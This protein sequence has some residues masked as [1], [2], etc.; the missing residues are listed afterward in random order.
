M[1]LHRI[2]SILTTLLLCSLLSGCSGVG[3]LGSTLHDLMELRSEV[4]KKFNEK[5]VNI[6]I[7]ETERH[8]AIF[9]TFIN[10]DLNNKTDAERTIRAQETAELVKARY[11]KIQSIDEIAV[12]FQRVT[13]VFLIFHY[14]E[15]LDMYGF[16]NQARL[17]PQ[18]DR[19]RARDEESKSGV[20]VT[21]SAIKKRTDIQTAA[22]Q[23]DGVPGRGLTVIPHLEIP[24]DTSEVTPKPPDKVSFDFASYSPKQRF[25]NLT[26]IA[27]ISDNKLVYQT[28]GQFSTSRAADNSLTEFL[29]LQIPYSAFKKSIEGKAVALRLGEQEFPLTDEQLRSLRKMTQFFKD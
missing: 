16:D 19:T 27:F 26:K 29:Y 1:S 23:L 18:F 8:S 24:V 11:P 6:N 3:K 15:G 21:Y 5:D 12:M 7:R 9:I 10:S 13:T 20:S 28:D 17:L 4:L 25:P 14:S 2:H 22:M